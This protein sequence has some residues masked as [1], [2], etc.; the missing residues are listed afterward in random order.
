MA[1]VS[2]KVKR[3]I[4][5]RFK[6]LNLTRVE[7]YVY[8]AMFEETF[9]QGEESE[10]RNHRGDLTISWI[11]NNIHKFITGVR[12]YQRF[13][14]KD[15]DWK[16]TIV[17][18]VLLCGIRVAELI[19]RVII[20][21][22]DEGNQV[23]EFE[24]IDGQQRITA[25]IE[26]FNNEFT[27]NVNGTYMTYEQMETQNAGMYR[28][29]NELAF[30]ACFYENITNEEASI[31]FKKV[32]DQTAI[33][34]QEDRHAI[35]GPYSTYISN[36]SYYGSD[37]TSLH[38]L[39]ESQI[40]TIKNKSGKVTNKKLV[41]PNFPKL[42]I[43]KQRMEQLEWYSH[44][45]HWYHSGLRS[46]TTQ[47]S[48]TF[49]QL[50]LDPYAPVYDGK[51]KAE[52]L[53]KIANQIMEAASPAQ[54]QEDISPMI[55]QVMVL[56]YEELT[57]STADI[58]Y[59][60]I[61]IDDYVKGFLS[62]LDDY[63]KSD[64]RDRERAEKGLRCRSVGPIDPTI[65]VTTG[66]P[67]VEIKS[68]KM[69]GTDDDMQKMKDLF[70]GHNMKAIMTILQILEH[71]LKTNPEQFGAVELDPIRDFDKDMVIEKWKEQGK[72]DAETGEPL[73]INNIVGDHII[74]HS[75][76]IKKGGVTTW[77]N[78]QVIAKHR[79]LKKGNSSQLLKM[80]A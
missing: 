24:V 40:K 48:H 3:E 55:L 63:S 74:P 67:S 11:K 5:R 65:D 64:E 25:F 70:G 80:A 9:G 13:K 8:C 50:D 79:N 35:F 75:H 16:R 57:K 68:W 31:I 12:E 23:F 59:W 51:V 20:K 71:E 77:E 14:V 17:E 42:D 32:N 41:L 30:G 22:D 43:S 34:C 4:D 47:D 72:C 60:S 56:W 49:W 7:E 46:T 39:F 66:K 37:T 28:K 58:G 78:L 69:F 29:F 21:T 33:N 76:G 53:L 6:K 27:I 10:K 36:R 45:I 1:S 15:T 38:R 18:D 19:I 44:L 52:K 26:F 73:D 61:V 2:R 62:I 54:R